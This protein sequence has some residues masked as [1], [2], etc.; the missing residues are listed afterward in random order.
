MNIITQSDKIAQEI[1]SAFA[2]GLLWGGF[3]TLLFAGLSQVLSK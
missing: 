3:L 2:K 1:Q